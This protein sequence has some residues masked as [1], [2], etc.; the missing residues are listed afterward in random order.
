MVMIETLGCPQATIH[1]D[2]SLNSPDK[3]E[4][5]ELIEQ[6]ITVTKAILV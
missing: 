5:L 4:Y 1:L 3:D 6:S 2:V